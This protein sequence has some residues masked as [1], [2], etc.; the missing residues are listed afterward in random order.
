M[1]ST[2]DLWKWLAFLWPYAA[3]I[4]SNRPKIWRAREW[5]WTMA[6]ALSQHN[7]FALDRQLIH[8][9]AFRI[10]S[11][12]A[13]AYHESHLV[14]GAVNVV[15]ERRWTGRPTRSH[16]I[17]HQINRK[18]KNALLSNTYSRPYHAEHIPMFFAGAALRCGKCC[19]RPTTKK[20]NYQI[21]RQLCTIEIK[22]I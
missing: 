17:H 14:I 6:Y 13:Y 21:I 22:Y 4:P 9:D 8:S 16:F 11:I 2:M 20:R 12:F 18:S 19:L 7:L 15:C 3:H 5:L 10:R 1:R